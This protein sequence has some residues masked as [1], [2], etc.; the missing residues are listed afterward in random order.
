M[1]TATAEVDLYLPLSLNI[2]GIELY[3]LML[4]IATDCNQQRVAHIIVMKMEGNFVVPLLIRRDSLANRDSRVFDQHL[5]VRGRLSIFPAHKAMNGE[6]MIGFMCGKQ[7]RRGR[8][9]PG[10]ERNSTHP[11]SRI[12]SSCRSPSLPH[13][14]MSIQ[15]SLVEPVIDARQRKASS[16]LGVPDFEADPFNIQVFLCQ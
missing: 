4:L 5:D 14:P 6:P 12:R 16:T 13:S 7:E 1:L 9:C 8:D 3:F 11:P 10:Y 15:S 2:L